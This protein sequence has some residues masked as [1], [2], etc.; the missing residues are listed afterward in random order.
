[1]N[2]QQA[3]AET[4]SP[5]VVAV[6]NQKGGVAKTTSVVSLAGALVQNGKEVLVVDLDAQ[7]NLTLALGKDPGRVRGSVAEVLFN[8]A[9]LLSA[10]RETA[11]PGLDLVPANSAMETAERFLPM[12][13]N[14]ETILLRAIQDAAG[15]NNPALPGENHMPYDYILLDCPPYIGAV[16]LNALAAANM[17]IIPTQPEYF[18]AHA[19]RTMIT[20]VRQAQSTYNPRPDLSDLDYPYGSPQPHPPSGERTHT[21][22]FLGACLSHR[23][24]D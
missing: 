8:N 16:T 22:R 7:A 21:R 23:H 4:N 5:F 2:Q 1:M 24:R 15:R 12:R 11:I 19:L 17:L 20:T 3:S 18:S 13:Q 6:A 10:S 9:T 14:Y